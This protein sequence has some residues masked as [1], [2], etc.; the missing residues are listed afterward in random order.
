M[1]ASYARARHFSAGN[2]TTN[3]VEANWNQLKALLGYRPGLD[4][5]IAG[6]LCHQI[7]VVRQFSSAL[8]QYAS[9]TRQANAV[10]KYLRSVSS[11]LSDYTYHRVRR[12]W[13]LLHTV[14]NG[15][16]CVRTGNSTKWEVI[17]NYHIY[18]CDT[19]DWSCT[20]LFH[21]SIKL[22]CRHLLLIARDGLQ[23]EEFPANAV[24]PRWN[25]GAD[26]A[27]FEALEDGV[28]G[29]S[30][31]LDV[32]SVVPSKKH[33]V[34]DGDTST[35]TPDT[36]LGNGAASSSDLSGDADTPSASSLPCIT[37]RS[38][39]SS[40]VEFVR[41][42][43][44][45][46]A[47]M[48][49]LSSAEKYRYALAT[50]EPLLNQLSNMSSQQFYEHI[51]RWNTLLAKSLESNEAVG[52]STEGLAGDD[53]VGN[54]SDGHVE[55]ADRNGSQDASWEKEDADSYTFF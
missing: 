16:R 33:F 2:T 5:T 50:L 19:S 37:P 27:L 28:Y 14:M 26:P 53:I 6:L 36:L 55:S 51:G 17:S 46:K 3:R 30:A 1:W 7:A 42:R 40:S 41:L 35:K 24:V 10:P 25:V 12:E 31:A 44:K 22:P 8:S 18:V 9:R 11:V 43:R 20:C 52:D 15:A 38:R 45:E 29:I 13:D 48:V 54:S 49:V 39:K 34:A 47:D 21:S 32:V 23:L 4:R